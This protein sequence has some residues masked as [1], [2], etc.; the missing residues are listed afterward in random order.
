MS[1]CERT[2]LTENALLG[3]SLELLFDA[4]AGQTLQIHEIVSGRFSACWLIFRALDWLLL[5]LIVSKSSKISMIIH[6]LLEQRHQNTYLGEY[7]AHNIWTGLQQFNGDLA[8]LNLI[9]GQWDALQMDADL[10]V[11]WLCFLLVY[12]L[13]EYGVGVS[14]AKPT[15]VWD[16]FQAN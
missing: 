4:F 13:R 5:L 2:G 9:A 16:A 6:C 14:S 7:W 12:M 1:N 11:Q 15:G 3:Q 8:H 10:A